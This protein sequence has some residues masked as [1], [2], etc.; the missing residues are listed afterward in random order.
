MAPK[1]KKQKNKIVTSKGILI[2]LKEQKL[3]NQMKLQDRI[4][5]KMLSKKKKKRK[6]K[7]FRM[8]NKM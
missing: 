2:N 1:N 5:M 4:L 3:L 8:L 6:K 7:N